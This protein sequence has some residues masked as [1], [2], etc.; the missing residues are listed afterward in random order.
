MYRFFRRFERLAF[1]IVTASAIVCA[2]IL[3]IHRLGDVSVPDFVS[4]GAADP[5]FPFVFVC[6]DVNQMDSC[7]PMQAERTEAK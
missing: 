4:Q 3:V 2:G 7:E 6:E 5:R 1:G